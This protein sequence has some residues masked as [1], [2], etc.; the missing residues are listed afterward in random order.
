MVDVS[1]WIMQMSVCIS[2]LF[3]IGKQL[4]QIIQTETDFKVEAWFYILLLTIPAMPICWINSYTFA[5]YFSIAG[6]SVALIGM[7]SIFGYCVNLFANHEAVYSDLNYFDFAGMMGHIGVAMFVFEGNAVIMNVRAETKNINQYPRILYMAIVFTV[8]LFMSFASLCYVTYR[9][10]TLPIFVMSLPISPFTIFIRLCTCF[11]ALC[12]YPVQ[13]LAAFEIYENHKFF[14]EGSPTRQKLKR[15]LVRSVIVWII[16]GIA[17]IIPNFTDF[18][19]IAGSIGSAA[20]AFVIPPLI[21]LEEF[22]D[23]VSMPVK[24]FNW[25]IM[26]FGT[27]GAIYSTYFSI[28]EMIKGN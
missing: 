14:H 12:S 20:I 18:L 6:I 8:V 22:K 28:N 16:T 21:Y 17:L 3:F 25:F 19:N 23:E 7:I 15:V 24:L 9:D 26:A 2:Y 1:I 27:G 10:Q 13:I 5:S 11:N 4:A